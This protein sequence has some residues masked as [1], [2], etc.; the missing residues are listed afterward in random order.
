MYYL[1]I[2]IK[3]TIIY[4]RGGLKML[5]VC[6][7][8]GALVDV[9]KDCTCDNCGIR[10]CGEQM[11]EIVVNSIDASVEKHKPVYE[12]VGEY[13]VAN[14]PHV[15]EDEHY[16]DFIGI[17]SNRVNAKKYFKAG[18]VPKAIFPYIKGSKIVAYCN[19]HGLWE[20]EVL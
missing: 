9:I 6:K 8:C 15:M 4:V 19:K 18:E 17:V 5:K 3:N 11:A 20:T 1:T 16:I 7:Q 10:C 13:I 12:I 14:V 2:N